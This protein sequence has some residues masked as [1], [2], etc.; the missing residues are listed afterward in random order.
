M[1]YSTANL[2]ID[3]TQMV[4]LSTYT[5]N[6]SPTIQVLPL[7]YSH[8]SLF[9]HQLS[10]SESANN[11]YQGNRIQ[12]PVKRHSNRNSFSVGQGHMQV[13]TVVTVR[14]AWQHGT[15][16]NYYSLLLSSLYSYRASENACV[17]LMVE[18]RVIWES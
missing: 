12:S 8:V 15:L 4:F 17:L 3:L 18:G 13:I 16:A 6:Y 1:Q 11:G 10:R 5:L 7:S 14:T 2:T 9:P